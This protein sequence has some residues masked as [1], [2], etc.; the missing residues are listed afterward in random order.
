M[1][2]VGFALDFFSKTRS[3]KVSTPPLYVVGLL[4]KKKKNT[5]EKRLGFIAGTQAD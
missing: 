5:W 1:D 2:C 4:E 3:E